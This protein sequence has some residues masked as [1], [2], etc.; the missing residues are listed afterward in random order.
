MGL[1]LSHLAQAALLLCLHTLGKL[2]KSFTRLHFYCKFPAFRGKEAPLAWSTAACGIPAV[3]PREVGTD[4]HSQGSPEP[5]LGD[6]H[7]WGVP[8]AT[9]PGQD[10]ASPTMSLLILDFPGKVEGACPVGKLLAG[11]WEPLPCKWFLP[12]RARLKPE[13]CNWDRGADCSYSGFHGLPTN[14]K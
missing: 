1:L 8:S 12:Y 13:G 5:D 6:I 2:Q 3:S 14:Y 11:L 7:P 9:K 10:A 4:L